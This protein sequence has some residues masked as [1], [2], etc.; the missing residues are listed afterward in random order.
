MHQTGVRCVNCLKLPPLHEAWRHHPTGKNHSQHAVVFDICRLIHVST[1]FGVTQ[2]R[3]GRGE[4]DD[5]YIH[6][7][8]WFCPPFLVWK[9]CAGNLGL[10]LHFHVPSEKRP[11]NGTLETGRL[12][13]ITLPTGPL[14]RPLNMLEADAIEKWDTRY[15]MR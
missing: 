8:P 15:E 13:D 10:Q 2:V 9:C 14:L 7:R 4:E 1:Q 5:I 12:A 11:F 6:H 3:K